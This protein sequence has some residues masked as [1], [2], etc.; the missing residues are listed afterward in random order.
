MISVRTIRFV[1]RTYETDT[2]EYQYLAAVINC[3]LLT[4]P[5]PSVAQFRET[6]GTLAMQYALIDYRDAAMRSL[7]ASGFIDR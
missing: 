6:F 3:M 2:H 1:Q 7:S 5:E 4:N